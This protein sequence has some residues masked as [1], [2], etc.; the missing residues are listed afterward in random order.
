M[1]NNK[2]IKNKICEGKNEPVSNVSKVIEREMSSMKKRSEKESVIFIKQHNKE[3]EN[4]LK[5]H[6]T[7]LGAKS[8]FIFYFLFFIFYYFIFLFFIY[9]FNLFFIINLF[10]FL[11]LKLIRH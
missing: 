10:H 8:I 11:K 4:D 2:I 1:I 5:Y 9:F 3:L 6:I 7:I